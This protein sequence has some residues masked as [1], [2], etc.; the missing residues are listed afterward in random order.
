MRKNYK[1]IYLSLL[2]FSFFIAFSQ[3]NVREKINIDKNWKFAFGHQFDTEKDFNHATSYFSYLAKTGYADGPASPKFDDRAWRNLNLPHDWAVEQSFS[4]KASFSH[5]FKAA[6]KGFPEKNIGWYR[7]IIEIDEK[8]LGKIITLKFD[9]VF[10]N[11]KVFFNGHYLGTEESG[12]NGFEYD[13]TSYIN[14]GGKNTIAVRADASMEEGWYY[15]G[16]ALGTQVWSWCIY[17]LRY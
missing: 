10:R 4:Q 16:E 1:K 2:L 9:G 14:Y 13:I 11:S 17:S 3:N 6:G 12:Y 5:G 7:K 15:E 8:D